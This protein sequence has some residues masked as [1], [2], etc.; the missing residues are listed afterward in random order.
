MNNEHQLLAQKVTLITGAAG[1]IGRALCHEF[2]R[3][4]STVCM[5][6]ITDTTD[7]ADEIDATCHTIRP[8]PYMCDISDPVQVREM[9]THINRS[10]TGV[11]VLI[12]NAAVYGPKN[13]TSFPEMSCEGF[14]KA[15]NINLS[16]AVWLTL[17]TLP[18]MRK[19]KWGRI[20][21][22]AAPRS[23]SGIP[24]PY[25]AGKSGFISMARNLFA[26]YGK[27]G[28]RTLALALRHTETPMIRRVIASKGKDVEEELKKMH[29][30][31]L[32]GRMITPEEIATLYAW[33][34]AAK[35]SEIDCVSLLSD[36]GITYMR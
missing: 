25:M 13:G 2:A 5:C 31:S 26:R 16:A 23:S 24:A 11:D 10:C 9:I 20:I 33:F 30:R 6:D 36:G 15:L 14:Q 8:V 17:L 7:L 1:G 22:T 4:G 18:H 3:L 27:D 35:A 34:T 29:A 21:F 12:N 32:T 28:I 19:H